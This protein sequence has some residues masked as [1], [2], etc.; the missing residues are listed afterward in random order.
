MIQNR[1]PAIAAIELRN[2]LGWINPCDF[3]LDIVAGSLGI[4]IKEAKLRG[5]EGRIVMNGGN[6][7]ISINPEINNQQKI[8][9]IIAHEIGHFILHQDLLICSDTQKT[10][11]E[12]HKKGPQET[13]ANEFASELLMPS[14]IFV[15]K[16]HGQKLS[17][18]LLEKVSSFFNVSK[19]AAF[20]KYVILGDYPV[21]V[22]YIE[23]GVINW[24]R[25]SKDFPFHYLPIKS[26]VPVHTVAGDYF[27]HN[28][29]ESTPE[30]VDAIEWFPEDF[31]INHKKDW[32]LWEQCYRVSDEGIVSCLWTY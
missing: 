17:L 6:G 16:V 12:W 2:S 21:M 3:S 10:L 5:A 11:S 24:K 7:I 1:N 29:F 22:I 30:K 28:S 20:L 18:D 15:Q 9:F 19:L 27:Y 25:C 4:S 8:N 32:K 14:G 23:R 31:E 13:E 26:K